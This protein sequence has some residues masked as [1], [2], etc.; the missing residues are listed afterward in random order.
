[1]KFEDEHDEQLD[2]EDAADPV[3]NL[4]LD[5]A[6]D[7]ELEELPDQQGHDTRLEPAG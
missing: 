1:M 4:D 2:T 3:S 7:Q 5:T 6:R